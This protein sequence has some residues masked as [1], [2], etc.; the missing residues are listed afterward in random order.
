MCTKNGLATNLPCLQGLRV[1][2]VDNNVD[3]CDLIE[4]LLRFY[5]VEVRKAFV[6]QQALKI[7]IEWQPDILVSEVA[8]P[9]VDGFTLVQQ[10]RTITAERGKELLVIA[11]T[12]YITEELRQ[13]ALS[14]G[15]DW[16]FTKPLDLNNFLTV[17]A[18][19]AIALLS[20][21]ITQKGLSSFV[22]HSYV[23]F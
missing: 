6:A 4:L 17:L 22:N 11:V 1:L 7:F 23:S 21:A 5:G 20:S 9:E 13:L 14:S 16:W 10:A 18:C 19:W 3:C 12:A 15:F 8:L 2:V